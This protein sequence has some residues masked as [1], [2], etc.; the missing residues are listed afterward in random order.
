MQQFKVLGGGD[1]SSSASKS[2][3]HGRYSEDG[4]SLVLPTKDLNLETLDSPDDVFRLLGEKIYLPSTIQLVDFPEH[5]TRMQELR[6]LML[7]EPTSRTIQ[8]QTNPRVGWR[9][10][11]LWLELQNAQRVGRNVSLRC[12]LLSIPNIAPHIKSGII[13]KLNLLE[14]AD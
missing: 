5:Q 2:L 4:L 11:T 3:G 13:C 12:E 14:V 8:I 6:R 1:G 9:E 7:H 10:E